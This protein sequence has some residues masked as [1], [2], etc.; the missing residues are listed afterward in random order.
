MLYAKTAEEIPG[1]ARI[2]FDLFEVEPMFRKKINFMKDCE[3]SLE[4][5]LTLLP[6]YIADEYG[7]KQGLQDYAEQVI[8]DHANAGCPKDGEILSHAVTLLGQHMIDRFIHLGLYQHSGV[9]QYV[10]DGWLDQ[11]SPVFKK[12]TL[13]ELF[14]L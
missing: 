6:V 5:V 4:E 3:G 13:Q 12:V 14:E 9:C 8:R 11:S 7:A 10:F 2:V 1:P